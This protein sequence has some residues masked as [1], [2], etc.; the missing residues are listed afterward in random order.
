MTIQNT[1]TR[2]TILIVLFVGVLM[3]ALD[4]AIVGPALPSIRKSFTV[5]E[6]SMSWVFS[7]YVLL[8]LVSTPLMAKLSDMFGRRAVYVADVLLF[9]IGSVIV[10][11]SPFVG[12][13]G[14]FLAGRAIQGF[15]AGGIFP[16]AG[17]VIG[18]TFP[19][20]KR[21]SA[22]GLIGAVFGMAF[23]IG[24]ILGAILL[25]FG[26]QWLFLINLPIAIIVIIIALK[27]I[28]SVKAAVR[29]TPDWTGMITLGLAL[30]SLAY[31]INQIDT[32]HLVNS[33]T[34]MNM[35]PFIVISVISFIIFVRIE[36]SHPEPVLRLSLFKSRQIVLSGVLTAG[37]G[38]GMAGLIF[39]PTLA[40]ATLGLQGSSASFILM[41]IVLAMSFGS[42]TIG[43]LLNKLGSKV[44]VMSG[45]VLLAAGMAVLG[46]V[47]VNLAMFIFAGVLIGFGLSALLGA[48]LRYIM[49]NE[50]PAEDR[51]AGQG[52]LSLSSMVGQLFC[53]VI[54]GAVADSQGGG[55]LGFSAAFIVI[56]GL[57]IVFFALTLGLKNRRQEIET[58]QHH[59]QAV[60]TVTA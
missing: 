18:D 15:G 58:A 11:I 19:P 45:M 27:Y 23:I 4:I 57:A 25:R 20:E 29:P 33:I 36:R 44:I 31:A 34:S 12:S 51:A 46:L 50:T 32:A 24:P 39:I 42:P 8:Q 22:L 28:P 40:V 21:G 49:L 55:I 43:R 59:E 38:L 2:N 48:P 16:V 37:A 1:R 54:V 10:T 52:L 60:A 56:S 35:W 14:V 30:T 3:G 26:W 13:F 9:A 41:P 17:A 47:A 6:R 5:D 53:A 7:I